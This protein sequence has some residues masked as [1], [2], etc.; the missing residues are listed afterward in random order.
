VDDRRFKDRAEAAE[1]EEAAAASGA[2][3]RKNQVESL[4]YFESVPN[5]QPKSAL[6]FFC[7]P[8][9]A[10][11]HA[12]LKRASTFSHRPSTFIDHHPS[13]SL[14]NPSFLS[15]SK[16]LRFALAA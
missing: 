7:P 16:L 3:G 10:F 12:A 14:A 8:S 11:S 1:E 4:T 9:T 6:L 13:Q 5:S 2:R 15:I